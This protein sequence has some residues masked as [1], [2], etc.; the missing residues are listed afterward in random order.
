M[1]ESDTWSTL[2][3][4]LQADPVRKREGTCEIVLKNRWL[5]E[6]LLEIKMM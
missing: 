5:E 2:D 1:S 3:G 6:S 4:R